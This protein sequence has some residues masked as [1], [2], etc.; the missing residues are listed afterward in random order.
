M[1]F[2]HESPLSVIQIF[3]PF[4]YPSSRI[5]TILDESIFI[6]SNCYPFCLFDAAKIHPLFG[7]AI[8][9][10]LLFALTAHFFDVCQIKIK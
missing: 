8:S 7:L 9:F 3:L 10:D 4:L 6:T 1:Y 2:S 5:L